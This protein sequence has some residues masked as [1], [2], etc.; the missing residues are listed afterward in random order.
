MAKKAK[1]AIAPILGNIPYFVVV[2]VYTKIKDEKEYK[3]GAIPLPGVY[4]HEL[5]ARYKYVS[6]VRRDVLIT[7][8]ET[9]IL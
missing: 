3:E 5:L 6:G 4:L 7:K 8:I 1:E 2:K 9:F